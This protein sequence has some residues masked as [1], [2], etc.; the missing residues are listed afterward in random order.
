VQLFAGYVSDSVEMLHCRPKPSMR[1]G[2]RALRNAA[3][4][5]AG[6]ARPVPE[7]HLPMG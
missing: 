2:L 1:L 7:L 6:L 4:A 3:E 5:L